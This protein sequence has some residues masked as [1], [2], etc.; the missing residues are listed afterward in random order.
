VRRPCPRCAA[1]YR[2][3][4]VIVRQLEVSP[5]ELAAASP[6]RG[7]GCHECGG[8]GYRGRCAV[9]EVLD[10]DAPM[11]EVLAG[12]PT[13]AAI[14]A[15]ARTAGMTSLRSA[16]VRKALAGATTLEEA[17]RVTAR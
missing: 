16:A 14:A 8:T 10:V 9:Y 3:D 7:V 2:P 11:R 13:E 15:R 4:P 5:P 17:A 1:P 6:R 12:N